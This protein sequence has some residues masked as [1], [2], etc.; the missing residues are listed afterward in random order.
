VYP[1]IGSFLAFRVNWAFYFWGTAVSYNNSYFHV[2]KISAKL[3]SQL[4]WN[5]GNVGDFDP[6]EAK[7]YRSALQFVAFL[8]KRI[9]S[10]QTNTNPPAC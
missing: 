7:P 5:S 10:S 9:D 2:N 3:M 4:G 1:L 8:L 6:V